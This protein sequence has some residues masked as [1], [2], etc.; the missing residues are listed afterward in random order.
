MQGFL[1]PLLADP[2]VMHQTLIVVTFD[3]S[4]SQTTNHIYT[5]FLGAMVK[6]GYVEEHPYNHDNVLRTVEENFGLGTL[7]AE[8]ATSSPI[9]QV[10]AK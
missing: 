1:D 7:G 2:S 4:A 3:E 10:W 9:T 6:T 5:V 8:D